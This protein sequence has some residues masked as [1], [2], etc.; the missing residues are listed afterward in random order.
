MSKPTSLDDA[1]LQKIADA[2]ADQALPPVH[3][4]QP[5]I[6]RDIELEIRADGQWWYCGSRIQRERMVRLFSTVLRCDDDG[7]TYLVTP[8]ERLRIKVVDLPFMA[9][10]VDRHGSSEHPSFVMTTSVG[11]R[12]IAN[13]QHP[14]V[15]DYAH[16]DADPAPRIRIRDRLYARLSRHVFLQIAN[17]AQEHEG[18]LGVFSDGV[19]MPLDASPTP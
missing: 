10:L 11:D 1:R 2:I 5:D 15:V 18:R 14:I 8:A 4:W 19:F 13:A 3:A 12:V 6:T 17:E 7:Y 9:V 16:P